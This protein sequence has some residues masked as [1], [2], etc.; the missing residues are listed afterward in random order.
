MAAIMDSTGNGSSIL[1]LLE[2]RGLVSLKERLKEE[3]VSIVSQ[4]C[5]FV[6]RCTSNDKESMA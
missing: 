4:I 5:V 2:S 1:D 3:K 6:D